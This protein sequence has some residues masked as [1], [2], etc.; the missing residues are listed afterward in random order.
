MQ[1]KKTYSLDTFNNLKAEIIKLR[2]ERKKA[3][4]LDKLLS[5]S[6]KEVIELIKLGCNAKDIV[7]IYKK[8]GVQI[9][10][11]KIKKVFFTATTR[12]KPAPQSK[13]N[14]PLNNQD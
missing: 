11:A 7:N 6:K 9:G 2:D 13:V 4:T 8:S 14:L 5:Q 10:I 12:R 1:N 3:F